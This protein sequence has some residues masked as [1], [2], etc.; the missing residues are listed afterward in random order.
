[1]KIRSGSRKRCGK[2]GPCKN[3][4]RTGKTSR[5]YGGKKAGDRGGNT[6]E[7]GRKTNRKMKHPLFAGERAWGPGGVKYTDSNLG[8][9][10]GLGKLTRG[11]ARRDV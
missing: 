4:V 7:R 8:E 1:V 11:D 5:E 10:R 2:I 6:G 3:E 9:A